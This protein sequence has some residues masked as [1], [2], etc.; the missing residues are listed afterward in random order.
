MGKKNYIGPGDLLKEALNRT[1]EEWSTL[2]DY[3]H[4]DTFNPDGQTVEEWQEQEKHVVQECGEHYEDGDASTVI[5][6]LNR[7]V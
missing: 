4:P 7:S 3:G 6:I 5:N 1:D 2:C